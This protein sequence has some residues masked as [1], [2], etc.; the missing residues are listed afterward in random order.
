MIR[1]KPDRELWARGI[2][3]LLLSAGAPEP[4]A[5]LGAAQAVVESGWGEHV[6]GNNPW[7]IKPTPTQPCAP[8]RPEIR[9][10]PCLFDAV[11][12]WLY[13]AQQSRLYSAPRAAL[14]AILSAPHSDAEASA[15]WETFGREF[16]ARYCPANR[17]YA[18]LVLAIQRQIAPLVAT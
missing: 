11:K 6:P 8:G 13:L 9:A 1:S 18:D 5:L 2:Y 17:G 3:R 4:L 16:T 7:G 10:F 14:Q 12:A 15:A